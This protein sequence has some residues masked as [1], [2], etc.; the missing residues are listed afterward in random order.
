MP[1]EPGD[2][3][4]ASSGRREDLLHGPVGDEVAHGGAAV[5]GHDH[6]V[7][8]AQGDDRG[9]VGG[10]GERGGSG[11]GGRSVLGAGLAQ[12]SDEVRPRIVSGGKRGR[13]TGDYCPPFWT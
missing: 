1:A 3:D 6:A 7:G 10:G 8:V 4:R 12:E 13:A 2:G 11:R 9:G 5:A